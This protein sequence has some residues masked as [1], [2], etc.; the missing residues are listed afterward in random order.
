[1]PGWLHA[2]AVASLVLGVAC[3]GIMV[4]LTSARP[5]KMTVMRFVWPLCALFGGPLLIAFY[6]R[7]AWKGGDIPFAASVAKGTLHCGAGCA[8]ADLFA[9]NLAHVF[10]GVLPVFGLGWLFGHEIF[11]TWAMDYVFALATGIVFQY[12]AIAPMRDLSF[13]EGMVSAAKADVLSLTSWQV[14]MYGLMGIAHFV[15][16]KRVL[17]TPVDAGDALFWFAMQGAML[18]GFLTA[19]GPN[20]LLIR[21]GIKERM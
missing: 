12:F 18:A 21:S 19:Y 9:E 16:F 6:L 8:L 3:A 7:Y 15:I 1:M 4:V 11:A 5:P 13:R 17:N 2:L 20:W 14:G 10:P